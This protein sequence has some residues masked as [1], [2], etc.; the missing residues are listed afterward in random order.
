MRANMA[1]SE[2]DLDGIYNVGTGTETSVNTLY[3]ALTRALGIDR[4]AEHGPAKPGEQLRSVLD[5]TRLR[6]TAN[7]PDPLT[8]EQGM[9]RTV[10]WLRSRTA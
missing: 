5:G 4:L 9:E 7:L 8:I 6:K 1:A 10:A 2:L 3:A